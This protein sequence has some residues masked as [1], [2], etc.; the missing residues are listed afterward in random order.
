MKNNISFVHIAAYS[1]LF[2]SVTL[3]ILWACNAGG[4]KAVSLD[5]FVGVIV[6]LL[7]LVVTFA[8][9]W[10]IYNAMEI[11]RKIEQLDQKMKELEKLKM[12][13][14][15]QNKKIEELRHEASHFS[16]IG[17]AKNA[18]SDS[19]YLGAYR[20][21]QSA[22][23]HALYMDSPINVSSMVDDMHEAITKA[24]PKLKLNRRLY[25]DVERNDATIRKSKMYSLIQDKNERSFALFKE[26]VIVD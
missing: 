17:I 5:T 2:L 8:I 20:F 7:A 3:A 15:S 11:N 25:E 26:K 14:E 21:F 6:S 1:A 10:Q 23:N 13:F 16:A 24:N 9:G 18:L 19:D 12:Q 4:L 22:L